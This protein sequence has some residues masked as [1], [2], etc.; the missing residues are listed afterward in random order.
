MTCRTFYK[1]KVII[2]IKLESE[3]KFFSF[4]SRAYGYMILVV[5]RSRTLVTRLI[6]LCIHSYID[7]IWYNVDSYS[8][9]LYV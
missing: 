7:N 1:I 2:G 5:S 4:L 6:N 8:C 3:E 9:V